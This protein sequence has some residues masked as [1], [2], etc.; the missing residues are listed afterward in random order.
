MKSLVVRIIKEYKLY[1]LFSQYR[2]VDIKGE[3]DSLNI[4]L[5]TIISK[6]RNI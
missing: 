3:W 5:L 2:Y 4:V 1:N 6:L